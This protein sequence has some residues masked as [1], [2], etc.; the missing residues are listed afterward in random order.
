MQL[1]V[2]VIG[3]GPGGIAA[4]MTCAAAGLRV[5]IISKRKK[6]LDRPSESVHPGLASLLNKLHIPNAIETA[7]VG[8]YKGIQVNDQF[9]P[10]GSDE[11]GDWEGIHISSEI[12]DACLLSAA[13]Q[14]GVIIMNDTVSDVRCNDDRV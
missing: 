2:I 3:S 4:A 9:T 12:F 6:E 10:L 11:S 13:E 7:A 5:A 14:Q 8:K 1:D